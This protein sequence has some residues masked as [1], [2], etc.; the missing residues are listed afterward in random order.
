MTSLSELTEEY[1]NILK[2]LKNVKEPAGSKEIGEESNIPWRTVIT[3]LCGLK[4]SGYIESLVEG[5]Y[6]ITEKGRSFLI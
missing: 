6:R 5:R 4:T 3:K 1:K 2:A